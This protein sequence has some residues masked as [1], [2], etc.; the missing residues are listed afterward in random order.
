MPCILM[1][2]TISLNLWLELRTWD[3]SIIISILSIIITNVPNKRMICNMTESN[4]GKMKTIHKNPNTNSSTTILQELTRFC[5]Q[6][7]LP[8]H[9]LTFRSASNARVPKVL[10]SSSNIVSHS[11]SCGYNCNGM[12]LQY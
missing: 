7:C 1:P 3:D 9:T 4:G 12:A 11:C 10:S 2:V 5:H 8:T 6:T